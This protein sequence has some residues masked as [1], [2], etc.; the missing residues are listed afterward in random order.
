M[1]P[2]INKTEHNIDNT[3]NQKQ[4]INI[5]NKNQFHNNHRINEHILKIWSKNNVLLTGPTK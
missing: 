4:S 3:L 1:K 2:F 5:Y